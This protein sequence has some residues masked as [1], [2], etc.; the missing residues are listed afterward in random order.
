MKTRDYIYFGLLI[1]F[2]CVFAFV[3]FLRFLPTDCEAI[4]PSFCIEYATY[5]DVCLVLLT[6]SATLVFFAVGLSYGPTTKHSRVWFGLGLGYSIFFAC[7]VLWA[8]G[9]G[10]RYTTTAYSVVDIMLIIAHLPLFY[11]LVKQIQLSS[12]ISAN[13][14][15]EMVFITSLVSFVTICYLISVQ[16]VAEQNILELPPLFFAVP[17]L[18]I[19]AVIIL[20]RVSSYMRGGRLAI[21]WFTMFSGSVILAFVDGWIQFTLLFSHL[22]DYMI[23]DILQVA[24]LTVTVLAGVLCISLFRERDP[25][26]LEVSM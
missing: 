12:H 17:L 23:T 6:L 1:G 8:L 15:S 2:L 18:D 20:G 7:E 13:M 21:P 16:L 10:P 4:E 14:K 3:F 22:T 26:S 25:M 19:S 24:A 5:V 9:I 11:G